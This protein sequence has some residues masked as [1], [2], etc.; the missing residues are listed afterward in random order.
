MYLDAAVY[1]RKVGKSESA[2]RALYGAVEAFDSAGL[3]G[4]AKITA[5]SL[6]QMYP[7]SSYN[8]SAYRIVGEILK[9]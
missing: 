1:A 5:Q 8:D 7:N 2:E 6:L 9:K 3:K 4:D